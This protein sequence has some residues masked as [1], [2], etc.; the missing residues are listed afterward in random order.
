M[1]SHCVRE[2]GIFFRHKYHHVSGGP[3][4]DQKR[5]Q[6]VCSQCKISHNN[7]SRPKLCPC[8]H[9]LVQTK[10]KPQLSA[11]KLSGSI[12]SVRKNLHGICKRVIV[13]TNKKVCFSEDCFEA[14]AHFGESLGF[15]CEHLRAC[16]NGDIQQSIV[17][18]LKVSTLAKYIRDNEYLEQVKRYA[19]NNKITVYELPEKQVALSVLNLPSHLCESG[20][21][22]VDIKQWKCPL[23]KCSSLSRSRFLVKSES[24]CIH[25]LVCKLILSENKSEIQEESRSTVTKL[26]QFSKNKTVINIV[27]KV[28]NKLPSPLEPESEIVFLQN[29]CKVQKSVFESRNLSKYESQLCDTC[30]GGVV[31][32]KKCPGKS[33]LVTPGRIEE[34][35]IRTF[36]CKKCEIITYPDV[37]QEGLVLIC[38]TLIVSWSYLLDGRNQIKN[39]SI[40]S[41]IIS[42]PR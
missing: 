20:M 37:I 13:D 34:I 23:R 18:N 17:R 27:E 10:P 5:G 19:A 22:H 12:Y 26:H 7:R 38:D 6:T 25:L 35:S 14:R 36:V 32:R 3:V 33:Y 4:S 42:N 40:S 11:F 21:I 31:E 28:I 41:T 15:N 1:K 2:H 29:S 8:G 39:G 9:D 16:C 30:G 24:F